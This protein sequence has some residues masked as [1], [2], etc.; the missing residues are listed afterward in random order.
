MQLCCDRL[1]GD[2]LPRD[3]LGSYG[4]AGLGPPVAVRRPQFAKEGY[5]TLRNYKD[6]EVWQRAMDLAE[7]V[8]G[9]I[10]MLPVEEKFS[11]ADQMRRAAISVP[12]NIA[13]GQGR[14]SDKEF[15]HFL[16][17]ARGSIAE[18]ETQLLLCIRLKYLSDQ[19]VRDVL[20]LCRKISMMLNALIGKIMQS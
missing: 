16:Y 15:V 5:M 11:L 9:L 8:Y 3:I 2:T 13:E 14:Q 6:Y 17:I 1:S 10:R 4:G 20:N 7:D 18:L 19:L 12:S